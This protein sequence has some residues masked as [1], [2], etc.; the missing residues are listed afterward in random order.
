MGSNV[1][2]AAN[3]ASIG[4]ILLYVDAHEM[5]K[6]AR[7]TVGNMSDTLS[8]SRYLNTPELS[9]VIRP[10]SIKILAIGTKTIISVYKPITEINFVPTIN[11]EAL[12]IKRAK[13]RNVTKLVVKSRVKDSN[14]EVLISK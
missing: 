2:V 5:K 7:A 10:G 3:T 8:K 13:I 11:H 12:R 1:I 9:I 4:I 6:T 14:I